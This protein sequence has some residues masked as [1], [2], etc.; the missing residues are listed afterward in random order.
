MEKAGREGRQ[1]DARTN[2]GQVDAWINEGQAQ[3]SQTGEQTRNGGWRAT[4]GSDAKQ[5]KLIKLI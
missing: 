4:D 3:L 1:S 5:P 2:R